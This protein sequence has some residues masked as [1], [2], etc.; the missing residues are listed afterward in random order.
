MNIIQFKKV[1]TTMFAFVVI[2][3]LFSLFLVKLETTP[4][5][6]VIKVIEPVDTSEIDKKILT[7]FNRYESAVKLQVTIICSGGLGA[8]P[9]DEFD[10]KCEE[11]VK[12]IDSLQE[13]RVQ[14]VGEKYD[15]D[16]SNLAGW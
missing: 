11:F 15:L 1:T 6:C 14:M 7:K 8:D 3:I 12:D 9:P 13:T 16:F 4:V 2:T 10:K 5:K